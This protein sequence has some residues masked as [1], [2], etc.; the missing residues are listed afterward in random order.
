MADKDPRPD[1]APVS[2]RLDAHDHT[3]VGFLRYLRLIA[4]RPFH[5]GSGRLLPG[6][7]CRIGILE[8]RMNTRAFGL[9]V[10]FGCLLTAVA[11]RAHH[12]TA[13]IYDPSQEATV[14]GK[15]AA[16]E[17]VN[18]HG[19]ITVTVE[20]EDGTTTD[21]TFTTGSATALARR[22]IT[23]V[24]PNALTIGEELTVSFQPARNGAPLGGLLSVMRADGTVL[25]NSG[26]N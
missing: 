18:P 12:S 24:G 4:V 11:A 23:K 9:F 3:G 15:L 7:G 16:L 8:T 25:Q 19:T 21:W 2:Y 22:G 14:T 5:A 6:T 10:L 13:S 17:F 26:G 20:N 1:T